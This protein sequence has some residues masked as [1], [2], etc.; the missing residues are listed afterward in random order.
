MP[1][2]GH[3]RFAHYDK[4]HQTPHWGTCPARKP[5]P[6]NPNKL[7]AVATLEPTQLNIFAESAIQEIRAL[8]TR[9]QGGQSWQ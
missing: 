1:I 5:K 6:S 4:E 7:V 3:H 2:D 8:R 9:Q